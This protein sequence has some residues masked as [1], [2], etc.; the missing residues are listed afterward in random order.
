MNEPAPRPSLAVIGGTGALG[1]ALARRAARAGLS[2]YIGSR[3]AEKSAATAAAIT[4]NLPDCDVSGL[5][6]R[7]AAAAAD[8]I[9]LTVPFKSQQDSLVEIR[10]HLA[11]KIVID[12]TVPLVPPKVAR[13]QLPPEGSAALRAQNILAELAGDNVDLVSALH[14][15]AAV[16]LG[17]DGTPS[18]DVLVFGDRKDIR[19]RII[20][21]FTDMGL[22]SW[23]GGPLANSAAAE[24]MTSVLIFMNKTYGPGHAGVKITFAADHA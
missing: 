5:N 14:N 11:G 19:E 16:E 24:A 2:V 6:N 20:A 13:V 15:V 23:H 4:A 10:D 8:I 3:N 12:C 1:S 18:C 9:A 7:D 17:R 21:L 22:T